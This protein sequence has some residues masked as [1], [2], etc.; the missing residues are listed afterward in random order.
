LDQILSPTIKS[1]S[2]LPSLQ[3]ETSS[4]IPSEAPSSLT[5]STFSPSLNIDDFVPTTTIPAVADEYSG[6]PSNATSNDN[7]AAVDS[8]VDNIE[9]GGEEHTDTL[10]VGVIFGILFPVVAII[11]AVLFAFVSRRKKT[12]LSSLDDDKKNEFDEEVG[13]SRNVDAPIDKPDILIDSSF[14]EAEVK[15]KTTSEAEANLV[16]SA[17]VIPEPDLSS[18][19]EVDIMSVERISPQDSAADVDSSGHDD[20]VQIKEVSPPISDTKLVTA[21]AKEENITIL[22]SATESRDT[23]GHQAVDGA[24]ARPAP[25]VQGSEVNPE[26]SKNTETKLSSASPDASSSMRNI[27]TGAVVVGADSGEASMADESID[28]ENKIE[29]ARQN[30]AII[31]NVSDPS[32]AVPVGGIPS[33]T[34]ADDTKEGKPFTEHFA[35]QFNGNILSLKQFAPSPSKIM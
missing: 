23:S 35:C 10:S 34:D 3:T 2:L 5:V 12:Q 7:G 16:G 31:S 30:T 24:A 20:I 29:I 11:A 19:N 8:D 27:S 21:A 25:Y 4:L 17:L 9:K 22:P 6:R 13:A 1:P 28:P 14:G 15:L 33:T 26:L 18:Q 32:N